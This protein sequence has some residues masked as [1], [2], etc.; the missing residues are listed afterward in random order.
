MPRYFFH[1]TDGRRVFNDGEGRELSGLHAARAHA[2]EH[3]RDLKAAMCDP[4]IQDLSGWAMA[5]TDSGGKTVF[6][7]GFDM[8]PRTETFIKAAQPASSSDM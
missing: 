5:V 6:M 8:K 2:V 1:F 7:L 4:H 3:V